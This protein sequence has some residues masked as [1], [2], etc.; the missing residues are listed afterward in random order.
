MRESST[1]VLLSTADQYVVSS[2]SSISMA[3]LARS[4]AGERAADVV[5]AF[6]WRAVCQMKVGSVS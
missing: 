3:A 6:L 1:R 5:S 2:H 4:I